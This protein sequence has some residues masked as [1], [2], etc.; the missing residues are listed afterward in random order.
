MTVAPEDRVANWWVPSG[1]PSVVHTTSV[2][3]PRTLYSVRA[4]YTFPPAAVNPRPAFPGK[5]W[6]SW[7]VPPGVPS[8]AYRAVGVV[9]HWEGPDVSAVNTSLPPA[10]PTNT[11]KLP[12]PPGA[13]SFTIRVPTAV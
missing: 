9:P 2:G 1:V 5:N 10:S 7:T 4:K 3:W 12:A 6:A 13:R 11:G 8:V